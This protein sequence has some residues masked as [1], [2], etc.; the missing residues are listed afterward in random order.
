MQAFRCDNRERVRPWEPRW[1]PEFYTTGFWE[2]QLRVLANEF[3]KGRGVSFT[4]LNPERNRVLGVCNY[5]NIVH[6]TFQSCH[7]GY[8]LAEQA[9]GRG[10][11]REALVVSLDYMFRVQ[12]LH[13]VMA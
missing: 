12:R 8:A 6:G 10:Y 7:L 4:I 9:E 1:S 2:L 5:T 13:R 11:M 3:C